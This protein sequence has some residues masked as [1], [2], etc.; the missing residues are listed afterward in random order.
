MRWPR[1]DFFLGVSWLGFSTAHLSTRP[2]R[3]ILFCSHFLIHFLI[4]SNVNSKSVQCPT[5][6]FKFQKK[7]NGIFLCW[8]PASST[9]SS[10]IGS[11]HFQPQHRNS[12][13]VS[14][15][16]RRLCRPPWLPA[17][18]VLW[19]RLAFPAC[20]DV[21]KSKFRSD[22]NL[23]QQQISTNAKK[24]PKL[25]WHPWIQALRTWPL[26]LL[27]TGREIPEK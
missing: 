13:G 23:D 26:A 5:Q 22:R 6:T 27:S 12:W 10:L 3:C 4:L 11:Y 8:L 21:S 14:L 9:S 16:R 24:S 18:W 25:P 17:F 2:S 19:E 20:A 15:F 7:K 1:L